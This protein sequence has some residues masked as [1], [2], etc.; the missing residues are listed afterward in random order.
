ML[1]E[2]ETMQLDVEARNGLATEFSG[3]LITR[4]DP[5]YDE[6][7]RI[8]N[9]MIDKRPLLIARCENVA[10]VIAAVNFARDNN[11]TTAVR[12]GGHNGAGLALIDD[13]LVIDLS[14]M[15]GI[16]VEPQARTVRVD[17]GCTWGDVD[18]A[19][20]PFGLAVPSGII[21]T[22]GV[23]GLTLGG[24]HG[25]LT[26]KYGLTID[27][28]LA[29]DVVLADGRLVSA[30]ADENED[31][32][33]AVRGGGGNFGVVTSFLFQAHPVG[34]VY[35]GPIIW[36]IDQSEEIMRWY[37]DFIN[38]A[39][40]DLYGWF[41][42]HRVPTGSPLP[43]ALYGAHGCVICW[44]Y[45]GPMDKAEEVFKPFRAL[46][47]PVLDLAGPMPFMALQSMFDQ[48]YYPPGLQ[49]Y[50]KA[51]FVNEIGNEAIEL[52]LKYGSDLPSE[53]C[54]MHLYPINGAVHQVGENE[55]AFSY[56]DVT[57]SSVIVGVDPD[58]ANA[59][60]VS[61]WAKNYWQALHPFSAG[62]GYVNFMM[63]EGE[64][65]VRATYRGNYRRLVAIKSK[66]DPD[67]FFRVNQNI[68][69][70]S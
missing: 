21:S 16:R 45:T 47:T 39:P 18:Q 41:G 25:Y 59:E 70:Q 34:T 49:W 62:G 68:R 23:G 36:P 38:D 30:S 63:E 35:G 60:R 40:E 11:L 56:R 9:A 64:E 12:G 7:R 66:Y 28:L 33:W 19:T 53:L 54:T 22:T 44:C 24:G 14:P 4:A 50:W 29:V 13:G 55:T 57:F 46:G 58:P 2:I 27:N 20:D 52:H 69:P 37:L 26:R 61:Q 42:F 1:N 65:R 8:Y 32:F 15:K 5:A 67:N 31:L 10:D 6:A 17:G 48:I 51:D 3:D 43:E